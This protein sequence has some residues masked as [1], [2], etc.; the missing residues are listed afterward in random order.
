MNEN[1]KRDR[2]IETSGSK[3][4]RCSINRESTNQRDDHFSVCFICKKK[5]ITNGNVK[6]MGGVIA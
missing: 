5:I 1:S 6:L 2:Q 4:C 3:Y